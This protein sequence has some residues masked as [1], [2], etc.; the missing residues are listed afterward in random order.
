MQNPHI[1]YMGPEDVTEESL[2]QRLL[3]EAPQAISIDTETVTAKDRRMVGVGI[4][5]NEREAV[6]FPTRPYRSR[7][8][9]LAWRLM[10]R[11]STKVYF[12]ATYDV[13]AILDFWEDLIEDTPLDVPGMKPL[14]H[15]TVLEQIDALAM[16]VAD[17]SS[18]GQIQALPANTLQDNALRYVGMGIEAISDILPKRKTMLDLDTSVVAYK[19]LRDCLATIRLY[20][21]YGGDAWQKADGHTWY[22]EPNI[23]LGWYPN[24]PSSY[25]VTP[26]MKDCYQVD[27][28]L[29]HLLTRMSRKGLGLRPRVLDAW[30]RRLRKQVMF[31]EDICSREGFNPGSPQQVGYTLAERGNF[32]PLTPSKKQLATG[33]EILS[34]L[35]DPLATVILKYREFAKLLGTYIV[36]WQG[37]ERARTHFRMDLST[38]RLSSYERNMQNIPGQTDLTSGQ[39]NIFKPDNGIWSSLDYDQIE[40]R[41]FA[42]ETQ[43]PTMLRAYEEGSDIHATTQL[44]LWPDSSLKDKEYRRRA[45]VF[46]FGKVFYGRVQTLS[47]HTKLPIKVCAEYSEAWDATYPV[48]AA[49]MKAQEEGEDWIENM[50]G[51]RCRLPADPTRFTPKHTINCRINYPPQSGASDVVK[52]A[53]LR[54]DGYGFDQRLQVHDEVLVDGYVEF[55]Q[56]LAYVHPELATPFKSYHSPFWR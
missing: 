8:L 37:Q 48:A 31:Y 14:N 27:M 53:M 17:A 18:M 22:A 34:Q 52:R 24:E 50:F 4:G 33:E 3:H 36:P 30:Y 56:E 15:W 45:K 1:A 19:C 16:N 21:R 13:N 39:R 40:L 38:A 7:F 47:A 9:P 11:P 43:D 23:A 41:C 20:H 51:R 2:V 49:W 10:L 5:L 25:Y 26:G 28:K 35:S 12:N 32:L 54:C 55:P 42:Y 29:L 6:Y 46:N 44:V